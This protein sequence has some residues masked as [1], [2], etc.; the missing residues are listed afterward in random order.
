[1][2]SQGF[3]NTL[4]TSVLCYLFVY[5]VPNFRERRLIRPALRAISGMRASPFPSARGSTSDRCAGSPRGG[6]LDAGGVLLADEHQHRDLGRRQERP[7]VR[8]RY[9]G[10]LLAVIGHRAG[11]V[12]HGAN[13]RFEIALAHAIRVDELLPERLTDVR[14][15]TR[16][17][18]VDQPLPIV[19]S[20]GRIRARALSRSASRATRSGA[21]RM[22]SRAT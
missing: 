9:D 22:I 2:V 20:L 14:E 8:P 11:F 10:A 6:R 18:E 1:M 12:M 15:T 21:W 17:C 16:A 4:R 5:Y 13:H 7:R 19:A 3:I